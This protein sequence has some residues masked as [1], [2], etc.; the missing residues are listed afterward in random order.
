MSYSNQINLYLAIAITLI[1]TQNSFI[2]SSNSN[3]LTS[4][5]TKL[6]LREKVGQLLMVSFRGETANTAACKLIQ[7]LKIG[8]IVYYNWANDLSS[9]TQIQKLSMDL[10]TLALESRWQIPL[11]IAVDQEGGKVARCPI[12]RVPGNQALG[13]TKNPDLARIS[14]QT[15]GLGLKA[16]NINTNLAPVV[17]INSNPLNPVI[18]SRSFG[19]T[20]ELV[21]TFGAAALTGYHTSGIIT[22]LKHFPGHGDTVTDSH[23]DLPV[24]S[25]SLKE[26]QQTELYP[27]AQLASQT[28]MIMTAHILVPA[29][30][31]TYC[32]TLSNIAISYLRD[33]IGFQGIIITDSLVMAGV[34]KQVNQSVAEAAILA[35]VAGHD[36]VLLGGRQLHGTQLKKELTALDIENIQQAIMQAVTSGRIPETQINQSVARVLALKQKYLNINF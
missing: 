3:L 9:I 10:Q 24:I 13:L 5:V 36:I 2:N 14:A 16:L 17:D 1:T 4:L 31:P 32:T 29:L 23:L 19:D 12:T 11:L 25:K 35:L 33:K 18:N 28:D 7:E 30:D 22:T 15:T 20:P 34:L 21:T 6:T 27:F 8:G 26:L